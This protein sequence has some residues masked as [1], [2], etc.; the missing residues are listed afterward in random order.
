M[1]SVENKKRTEYGDFQTP[2][3][4]AKKVCSLIANNGFEPGSVLEPTCGKGAFVK[5]AAK[6]IRVYEINEKYV[7]VANSNLLTSNTIECEVIQADFFNTDWNKV[8]LDL[9]DPLLVIGNPPWVTNSVL[10]VLNSGNL[11]DK[12]NV[13]NL[14][15]I[16]AMMGKSNFDISEWML[17]RFVTWLDG[18]NA[19]LAVLC[20]SSVARR[21][22]L[23]AWSSSS[24]IKS[25]ATYRIDAKKRI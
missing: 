24:A 19:M 23:S 8:I 9:A 14:R 6:Q 21:V 5:A 22:L 16:E 2:I 20:K 4:L 11:P 10:G 13:D 3:G 25:A 15:G 18:K 17:R 7:G 12:S 1:K